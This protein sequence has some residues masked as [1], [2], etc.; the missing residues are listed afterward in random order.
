[1]IV[2]SPRPAYSGAGRHTEFGVAAMT[3]RPLPFTAGTAAEPR[4]MPLIAE[5]LAAEGL[6]SED[7]PGDTLFFVFRESAGGV[8]GFAGLECFGGAGLLR[9]LVVFPPA[10]AQAHGSAIVAWMMDEARRRGIGA[11]YLLTMSAAAFFEKLGFRRIERGSV[12]EGVA[13]SAEFA[14]LCPA[15]AVCLMRRLS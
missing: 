15:S 1:M 13:A 11:L 14:R 8:I 7:L 6:P 5:A 4:D 3:E 9:S 12:P 2:A 10:R